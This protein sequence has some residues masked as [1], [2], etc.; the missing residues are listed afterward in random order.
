MPQE[1]ITVLTF[2]IH[3]GFSILNR[4]HT[5]PKIRE[6]LE[7]THPDVVFLQE[8]RGLH[9][10]GPV[11]NQLE[12]LADQLWE[13]TAYGKNAV[14][15]DSHHGNAILSRFPF[16]HF[17]NRDVSLNPLEKRGIL[18][19]KV[20]FGKSQTPL[21]LFC[22]HLNLLN[23]DRLIQAEALLDFVA[24]KVPIGEPLI[25]GGDFNDW[26][27]HLVQKLRDELDP[28]GEEEG[29]VLKT[30]PS[31]FPVFCL[32]RIFARHVKL[33]TIEVVRDPRWMGMSD[34]LPVLARVG[35]EQK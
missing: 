7:N 4:H 19:G 32:D 25:V 23:R 17:E 21:H 22:L 26:S 33:Q 31:F 3:K 1:H 30:F 29:I 20:L 6:F 8:V 9:L 5:L 27:G 10:K 34:H 24:E 14:F 15:T 13:H 16:V 18:Y 28:L 11:E 35:V 12:H 2:N